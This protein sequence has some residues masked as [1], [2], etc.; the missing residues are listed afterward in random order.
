MKS[1]NDPKEALPAILVAHL[2][3]E[4]EGM[5]IE[6]LHSLSPDDWE[7]QTIA[8]KWRVKDT[9]CHLLDT[10]GALSTW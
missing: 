9:V 1:V 5:L 4:I 10:L 8:P 2:F 7:A 3:P 6:L